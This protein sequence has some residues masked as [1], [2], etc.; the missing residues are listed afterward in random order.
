VAFPPALAVHYIERRGG[1][2]VGDH[3]GLE[4]EAVPARK[5]R[6][7]G[8]HLSWTTLIVLGWVVY[9]LT[10]QPAIG[11]AVACT[12]FG[13]ADVQAA[14]WLRRVDPDHRRGV[15]CFWWYITFALWKVAIMA[16]LA[17]VMIGLIS[18]AFEGLPK[19]A[20]PPKPVSPVLQGVGVAMGVGFGL[21]L[22]AS[23]VAVWSAL[24]S[25]I[26]VWLGPAPHRARTR[27]YWPP[28]EG[29]VNFAPYVTFTTLIG[30]IPLSLAVV[31]ISHT[32]LFHIPAA[33]WVAFQLLTILL[34]LVG[35][36]ITAYSVL[37]RRVAAQT[38]RECWPLVPG[39]VAREV[40][41][42]P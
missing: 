18:A 10:S 23:Y 25:G 8:V 22:L 16:V 14:F 32:V 42:H 2:S 11:A 7:W 9:E 35:G 21:S 20:V 29:Q 12:K 17:A 1:S 39:E 4:R 33:P 37:S 3:V 15:T 24:R 41:E 34:L 38:L 19:R 40:P 6:D 31:I 13:W 30:S 36:L 27:R 5:E 28:S 26:R